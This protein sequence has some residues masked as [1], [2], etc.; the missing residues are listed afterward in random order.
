MPDGPAEGA[1]EAALAIIDGAMVGLARL[2]A[3]VAGGGGAIGL[4]LGG[5]LTEAH[6][7]RLY[8]IV[9]DVPA[10]ADKFLRTPDCI[11]HW[12]RVRGMGV[13][14]DGVWWVSIPR[15]MR[16]KARE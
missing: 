4:L 16:H 12:C 13:K 3:S 5:A 9:L 10:A 6:Y 7:S 14:V 11:R 1:R 15:V 8:T 2:R